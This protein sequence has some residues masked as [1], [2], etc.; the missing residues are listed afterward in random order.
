MALL[1]QPDFQNLLLNY[2]RPPRTF[3]VAYETE[4]TVPSQWPVRN[5]TGREYRPE[6]YLAAFPGL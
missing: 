3:W 1:R 6:D 2:P 5:G 4:D